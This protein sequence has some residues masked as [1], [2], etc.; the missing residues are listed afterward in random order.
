MAG[1]VAPVPYQVVRQQ[2]HAVVLGPKAAGRAAVLTLALLMFGSLFV[3]VF[4]GALIPLTLVAV[5]AFGLI[6]TVVADC[7][8]HYDNPS[9][10]AEASFSAIKLH[11]ILGII[12]AGAA[13]AAVG[14]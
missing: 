2:A 5:L 6:R 10:L 13:L 3:A 14:N 4:T 9:K 7:W 1:K 11:L 8:N 12:I